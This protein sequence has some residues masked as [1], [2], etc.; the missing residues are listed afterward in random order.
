M[1]D[2]KELIYIQTLF[3]I[4]VFIDIVATPVVILVP[5]CGGEFVKFT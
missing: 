5:P 4:P 2:L 3:D 1:T